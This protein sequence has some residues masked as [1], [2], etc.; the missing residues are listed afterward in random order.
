[1]VQGSVF[2]VIPCPVPSPSRRTVSLS[3]FEADPSHQAQQVI[4]TQ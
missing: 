3:L 4:G 1:M 2:S